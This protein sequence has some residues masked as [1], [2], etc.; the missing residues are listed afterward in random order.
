MHWLIASLVF[1]GVLV[2]RIDSVG[3]AFEIQFEE[4]I[5]A[6]ASTSISSGPTNTMGSFFSDVSTGGVGNMS[7]T[8]AVQGETVADMMCDS[9]TEFKCQSALGCI[10]IQWACDKIVDCPMAED[11][12]NCTRTDYENT[13]ST[14]YTDTENIRNILVRESPM[15]VFGANH[16]QAC[17][18][19]YFHRTDRTVS[20]AHPQFPEH[21]D[22]DQNC[23]YEVIGPEDF[24]MIHYVKSFHLEPQANSLFCVNDK[25]KITERF[26]EAVYENGTEF[27]AS[28]GDSES[29]KCGNIEL[30]GHPTPQRKTAYPY[31][32]SEAS[33]LTEDY[34]QD[35]LENMLNASFFTNESLSAPKGLQ[36]S[37]KFTFKTDDNIG[38]CGFN[39]IV[40]SVQT[41]FLA[42]DM[43]VNCPESAFECSDTAFGP[44]PRCIPKHFLCDG[45]SD[46]KHGEDEDKVT[47]S[48]EGVVTR[49]GFNVENGDLHWF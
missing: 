42:H 33:L 21:Y 12:M 30:T 45:V 13:F 22:K 11:E 43:S 18:S 35:Y 24:I 40:K 14:N 41:R 15:G 29:T 10:P 17:N 4:P 5:S 34:G 44:E 7:T 39:F 8:G 36:N 23:F 31:L 3:C 28:M 48:S 1:L 37:V 25:V 19:T 16:V 26:H 46:C 27:K 32:S 6:D 49:D 38:L 9:Q 2:R 20:F 47:C